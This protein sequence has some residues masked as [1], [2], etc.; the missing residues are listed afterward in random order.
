MNFMRLQ[1]H[2]TVINYHSKT[3][4]SDQKDRNTPL[5]A[6]WLKELILKA[7]ADDVGLADIDRP[8]IAGHR[9]DIL[10]IFPGTR[11]LVSF[12]YRLNP[13]N[14]RCVSR[15]ISDTEFIQG[16]NAVNAISRKAAGALWER[17]IHSLTVSAGF[18]M[19]LENW[20]AKMWPLSHKPVAVE[21]GL[22]HIGHHRLVIHPRFGNFIILG[23]ILLNREVTEYDRPL[24]FN[25]CLEC[26][27]CVAVCTVIIRNKT[28]EVQEG[29]MG[30]ADIRMTADSQTWVGFLAKEKNLLWALIRG[31]IRI[32]G[33]PALL[34]RFAQCF[35]A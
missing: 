6:C 24:D 3:S 10:D 34:K 33:S 21:A 15:A 14:I 35:P 17:G 31:K 20:P 29:L 1:E 25:P 2:P 9:Q 13:E 30:T 12:V 19:D 22:G 4:D 28:I 11:T 7:G 5:D 26:K 8:G 16:V 23:T 18:P 27:L 32:K